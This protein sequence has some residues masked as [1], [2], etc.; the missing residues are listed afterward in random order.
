MLTRLNIGFLSSIV[1]KV[2]F[3]FFIPKQIL[4]MLQQKWYVNH[5]VKTVQFTVVWPFTKDIMREMNSKELW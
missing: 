5:I 4:H 1:C 2:F 3:F